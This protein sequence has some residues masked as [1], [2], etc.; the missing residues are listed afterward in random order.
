MTSALGLIAT[1]M[2]RWDPTNFS[3]MA[4]G[5][6]GNLEA[7]VVKIPGAGARARMGR[8]AV[9]AADARMAWVTT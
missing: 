2:A 5:R 7:V 8:E 6:T 4:A 1:S 3:T 9:E